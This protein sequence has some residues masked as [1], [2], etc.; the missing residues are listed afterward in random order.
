MTLVK[1][2]D[3]DEELKLIY[4]GRNKHKSSDTDLFY[5]GDPSDL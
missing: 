5:P 2:S 1:N 3:A 4:I